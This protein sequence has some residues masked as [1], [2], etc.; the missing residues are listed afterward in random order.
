MFPFISMWSMISFLVWTG[1]LRID[2]DRDCD[3]K[4]LVFVMFVSH[5]SFFY[6][7]F[8]MCCIFW[9]LR[10]VNCNVRLLTVIFFENQLNYSLIRC[11][12][13][14]YFWIDAYEHD[15]EC[16]KRSF[17]IW[18]KEWESYGMMCCRIVSNFLLCFET[19]VLID[20]EVTLL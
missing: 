2:I 11:C 9:M 5:F 10:H 1:V 3:D 7:Q 19:F 12:W 14:M 15:N 6:F 8:P 18:N 16:K 17:A 13:N 4:I 20:L